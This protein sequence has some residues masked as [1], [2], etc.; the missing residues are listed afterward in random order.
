VEAPLKPDEIAVYRERLLRELAAHDADV[1]AVQRDALQPADEEHSH[2][3]DE[4]VAQA[5]LD[6]DL[7]RLGV[8][9]EL[10]YEI[11]EA[12]ERIASGAFGRC[13][14]CG[15]TIERAR[16]ELVPYARLCAEHAR[17]AEERS[18]T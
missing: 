1:D 2:S 18:S 3:A 10:G 11:H 17:A 12:L 9:D 4:P 5:A 14:T 6:A 16:L 8:E 13:E 7:V 15:R